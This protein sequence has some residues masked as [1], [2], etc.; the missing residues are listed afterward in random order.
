MRD[1]GKK[2]LDFLQRHLTGAG[3]AAAAVLMV[4]MVV[5]GASGQG[6]PFDP[7]EVDAW[8]SMEL[9]GEP[10]RTGYD[11]SGEGEDSRE[12]SQEYGTGRKR[13][14]RNRRMSR[15]RVRR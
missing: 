11:L 4:V 13:L 8:A 6:N 9:S 15:K 3:I 1:R 2:L 10:D 7:G 5:K 12:I 14:K